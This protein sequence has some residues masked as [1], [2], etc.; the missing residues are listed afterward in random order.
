VLL[1]FRQIQYKRAPNFSLFFHNLS[2]APLQI[3]FSFLR[4]KYERKRSSW[5]YSGIYARHSHS[6]D[7]VEKGSLSSCQEIVYMIYF[8]ELILLFSIHKRKEVQYFVISKKCG[9]NWDFLWFIQQG[10][11]KLKKKIGLIF[12][13]QQHMVTYFHASIEDYHVSERVSRKQ[14]FC[15]WMTFLFAWDHFI[16]CIYS[17]KHN[18]THQKSKCLYLLVQLICFLVYTYEWS[19]IY[20][21]LFLHFW[22][23]ELWHELKRLQNQAIE[24]QIKDCY[25]I[26][27]KMKEENA[28]CFTV[29]VTLIHPQTLRLVTPSLLSLYVPLSFVSSLSWIYLWTFDQTETF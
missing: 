4:V 16:H 14:D 13:I 25:A 18:H 11:K 6:D 1:H 19:D 20:S 12:Y 8:I 10:H 3:F 23:V 17:M 9:N 21:W 26:L 28:F 27:L 22:Q 24:S 29:T 15:L 2:D 7:R 5:Y